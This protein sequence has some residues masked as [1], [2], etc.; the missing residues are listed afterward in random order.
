MH[1]NGIV[2]CMLIAAA[3]AAAGYASMHLRLVRWHRT[4][5]HQ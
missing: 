2:T 1:A 5:S 4:A 3:A